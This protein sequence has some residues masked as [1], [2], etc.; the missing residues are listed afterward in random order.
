MNSDCIII[1]NIISVVINIFVQISLYFLCLEFTH[2]AIQ[3]QI[4][5]NYTPIL[6]VD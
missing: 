4:S 1:S 2:P 5:C 3:V 6:L